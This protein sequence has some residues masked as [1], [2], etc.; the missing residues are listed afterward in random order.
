MMKTNDITRIADA[1][2][3]IADALEARAERQKKTPRIP[4]DDEA[5]PFS[6]FIELLTD[7]AEALSGRM[8]MDEIMV[9]VGIP[10]ATVG[11]RHS[12]GHA[13]RQ[14][15]ARR[16]RNARERFY[17]FSKKTDFSE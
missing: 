1:L 8:T 15:G 7:K 3:R 4:R 11:E 9:A 12:M 13:L 17:V 16:G 5:P 10:S 14:L 2:E 6:H